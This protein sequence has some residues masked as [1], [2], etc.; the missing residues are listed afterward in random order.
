[1]YKLYLGGV[2]FPVAPKNIKTKISNKNKTTEILSGGEVSIIK[3]P[4]LT[5][6][7]FDLLL[8][9]N[10]YP[11]AI[12]KKKFRS[13]KYFLDKLQ[14]WKENKNK[15]SLIILRNNK[16]KNML[17]SANERKNKLSNTKTKVTIE[18]YTI[19]E[20]TGEGTDFIVTLKL[21]EYVFYKTKV[22]KASK[23]K[24]N[25]KTKKKK[26]IKK[27]RDTS[28]NPKSNEATKRYYTVVDG[29]CLWTIAQRYYGDGTQY[30]KIYNANAKLIEDTAK[31]HGFA[32]SSNGHWIWTG[33]KLLIP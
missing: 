3:S 14:K 8:P 32:S 15:I 23:P 7:E 20:D 17:L 11:F 18:D 1:M 26:K 21:K 19:K 22:V 9:N 31:A 33:E 12:Y 6:Y 4:G 28:S 5:T 27:T 30:T 2:L 29:D 24:K 13:A 16:V 10:K 25:K